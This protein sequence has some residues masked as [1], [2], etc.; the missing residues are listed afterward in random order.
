L[1]K[2][3]ED[4]FPNFFKIFQHG[5][6]MVL[7]RKLLMDI[8]FSTYFTGK[9]DPQSGMFRRKN[10]LDAIYLW[11]RSLTALNLK[12]VLF[13]DELNRIPAQFQ[14]NVKLEKY[15]L[16]TNWSVLEER[17]LCVVN[18]MRRHPEISR[19]F[20]TDLFDVEF[21]KSPFDVMTPQYDF[22]AGY[23]GKL[24]APIAGNVWIENEMRY[25]YGRVY[26]P[27]RPVVCAG[28]FGGVRDNV[29][30]VL[31]GMIADFTQIKKPGKHADMSVFIKNVYDR[32]VPERIMLGEP[33]TSKFKYYE[34]SGNFAVRH[35]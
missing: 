25:A 30:S 10:D 3:I 21:F 12:A 23:G 31:D 17:H 1:P 22:Y 18:Y 35:K 7:E 20:I 26:Y 28:V 19:V 27:D 4:E 33:L 24:M 6:I 32:F 29:I 5:D 15:E 13:H 8:I 14:E 2:R 9:H 34:R 11:L 16:R